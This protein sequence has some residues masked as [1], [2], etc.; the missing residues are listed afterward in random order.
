MPRHR[1]RIGNLFSKKKRNGMVD[2]HASLQ[3]KAEMEGHRRHVKAT[4][5]HVL[6]AFWADASLDRGVH[7]RKLV[8]S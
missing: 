5:Q 3:L 7:L 8:R 4:S 1:G 6:K 2:P